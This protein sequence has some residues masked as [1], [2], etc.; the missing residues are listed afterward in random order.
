MTINEFYKIS[1]LSSHIVTPENSDRKFDLYRID[2]V[3]NSLVLISKNEI[4]VLQ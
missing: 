3:Q 1:W 4:L 2:V